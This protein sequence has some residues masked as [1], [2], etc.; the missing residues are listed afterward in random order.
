MGD[1]DSAGIEVRQL[2]GAVADEWPYTVFATVG[3]LGAA[4]ALC[5][6]P[7]RAEIVADGLRLLAQNQPDFADR[8]WNAH[9]TERGYGVAD[10]TALGM[11][12]AVFHAVDRAR[13]GVCG[14][15][16]AIVALRLLRHLRATLGPSEVELMEVVKGD[17]LSWEEIAARAYDGTLTRQSLG[18]RYRR[19]GGEREWPSGRR[20]G[21][22]W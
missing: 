4:L 17:D 15:E 1:N 2:R 6:T 22:R 18:L 9:D 7:W 14:T 12:M 10:A 5:R 11:A 8:V 3:G 19:L 20:S 13:R 21:H 16:E